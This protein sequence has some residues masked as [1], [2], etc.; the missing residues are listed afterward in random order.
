MW[1]RNVLNKSKC[2]ILI[3]EFKVTSYSTK[4]YIEI[5]LCYVCKAYK[6]LILKKTFYLRPNKALAYATPVVRKCSLYNMSFLNVL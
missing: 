2:F 4:I 6:L 3:N 1:V 5:D